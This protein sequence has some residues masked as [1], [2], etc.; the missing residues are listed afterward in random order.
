MGLTSGRLGVWKQP[1]APAALALL[2][3]DPRLSR[4][5]AVDS[6]K[7]SK[8]RKAGEAGSVLWPSQGESPEGDPLGGSILP[9]GL[10][11][12]HFLGSLL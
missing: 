4:I 8:G 11:G 12:L 5:Q 6:P 10:P 2:M 9:K 1:F 7:E 3:R